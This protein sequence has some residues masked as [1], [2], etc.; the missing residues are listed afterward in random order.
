MFVV[1]EKLLLVIVEVGVVELVVVDFYWVFTF[2]DIMLNV[3]YRVFYLIF[4]IILVFL[5]YI[6]LI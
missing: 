4:R 6:K 5:F 1:W 3:L 2:I